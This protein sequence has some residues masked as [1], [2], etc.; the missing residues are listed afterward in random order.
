MNQSL[1]VLKTIPVVQEKPKEVADPQQDKKAE[2]QAANI[3][4]A[5]AEKKLKEE[6]KRQLEMIRNAEI[7][8]KDA[9]LSAFNTGKKGQELICHIE[10]MEVKPSGAG[11]VCAILS[12]SPKLISEYNVIENHSWCSKSEYGAA[13]AMLVYENTKA[14]VDTLYEI[15]KYCKSINFP[16]IEV[17]SDKKTTKKPLVDIIFKLLFKHEVIDHWGFISWCDDSN[18]NDIPGKLDAIT[19]TT[20]FINLLR[21]EDI[22]EGGEEEEII[23]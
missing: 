3:A 19:Q 7:A 12:N 23:V 4:K 16:K 20:E 22:G 11:L 15:Q 6:K 21:E 8:A 9:G 1:E 14:Q 13:V 17:V 5:E 18:D 10:S 2:K